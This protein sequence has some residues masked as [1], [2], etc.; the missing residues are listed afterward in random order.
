MKKF[1]KFAGKKMSVK[2]MKNVKGGL[3]ARC[4]KTLQG[5]GKCEAY[6]EEDAD[7]LARCKKTCG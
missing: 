7:G 6:W 4:P 2:E 3:K 1:E 5:A